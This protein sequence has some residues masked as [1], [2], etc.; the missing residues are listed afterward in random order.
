MKRFA[1]AAAHG[2]AV[3]VSLW[4]LAAAGQTPQVVPAQPG[5]RVPRPLP[6]ATAEG[7]R[8]SLDDAIGLAIANNEDLNVAVN[9]AASSD[10]LLFANYGIFD[11]FLSI[12]PLRSHS[13]TP[14]SSQLAGAAVT[15]S[16]VTDIPG[17]ISQLLPIGGTVSI[18]FDAN[19]ASTNSSFAVVNPAYSAGATFRINQPLLKGFGENPTKWQI[20]I[21]KNTR[22]SAYLDYVKSVQTGV[23]S[24]EQAYWDLVYSLQNLDVKRESLKIAQE[25]NRITQ[26]KIDVGSLAPIDITQTEVGVAQAEQDIITAE[27]LVGDAQDRLKRL[28]N[29]EPGKWDTPFVPTDRVRVDQPDKID[30]ASGTQTALDKRPEVLKQAYLVDSD[31]VRYDYYRNQV[32]PG[33]NLVGS[34]GNI[35]LAGTVIDP[36]TG[37][38]VGTGNFSDAFSQV[39]NGSFKNWS[40]GLN[41]SFPI[42]DRAARGQRDAARYTMDSDRAGLAT[43][44]QNVIVDVRS[45]ARAIDTAW[46]SIVAASKGRELAEKNLD[47]EKKKFDNGMSTTF[48]VNQVQRD[49][50]AAR[51]T[52]LQALAGYRKAVAT[53]HLSIADNLEWKN[54]K[55]EGIP[56]TTVPPTSLNAQAR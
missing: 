33:L 35:G 23:N 4:A 11:P 10:Y 8:L 21:A 22:D 12:S 55:I 17:Q 2:L 16:D 25:L 49:L 40:V 43:A 28:M 29:V 24:V 54:I 45:S 27:G 48:Q 18:G 15:R 39:R 19:R 50:S 51:T 41:F 38:I 30:F 53:Y 26:I 7:I 32:L 52:E 44:Q 36:N 3:A 5:Q 14:S 31:R 34:Y 46:R 9:L 56:A 47:A 37:N 42:L 13:E 6:P 1:R 20:Y